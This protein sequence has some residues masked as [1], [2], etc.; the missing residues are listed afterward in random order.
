MKE[1]I[2]PA[3]TFVGFAVGTVLCAKTAKNIVFGGKKEEEV[4][5][6]EVVLAEETVAE[7]TETVE[8]K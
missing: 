7:A 4:A 6:E 5:A 2:K 3:L 8:A 1:L